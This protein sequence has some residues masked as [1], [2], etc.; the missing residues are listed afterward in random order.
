MDEKKVMG[1]GAV[2][3]VL[4][5]VVCLTPLAVALLASIG[6]ASWFGPVDAVF[7]IV[8][9]VGVAALGYGA[10]RF[11]KKAK[12]RGDAQAEPTYPS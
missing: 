10:Y 11:Q 5:T 8:L 3:A 7:H 4:G 12:A 1:L 2:G 9:A 6:L